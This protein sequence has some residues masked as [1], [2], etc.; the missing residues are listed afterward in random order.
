MVD[1]RDY[2]V[3]PD[4][5][6]FERIERRVRLRRQARMGAVAAVVVAA[7]VAV[8]L[9]LSRGNDDGYT[10]GEVESGKREVASSAVVEHPLVSVPDV[11]VES[12]RWKAENTEV[13]SGKRKMESPEVKSEKRNV[14]NN[15][16]HD[17]ESPLSTPVTLTPPVAQAPVSVR[18]PQATI[19]SST[20]QP[21]TTPLAELILED[22]VAG[23]VTSSASTAGS[24]ENAPSSSRY[25]D[26]LWA[27]NVVM[28]AAELD[29]NRL[30]RV[31]ASGEVH[32]FRLVVFNRGGRQVFSSSDI[33]TP[34]DATFD[35]SPVPQGAYVWVARFRDAEGVVR[36]E[37]GTV[38]VVR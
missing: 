35:G 11:E 25:N 34:W 8:P 20:V 1:L 32:D 23:N 2:K 12:G 21:V 7:M 29:Q 37:K 22:D 5:G 6:L 30:F 26:M 17:G 9:L 36:Q 4:A 14:K 3:Q 33:T 38:T 10:E 27:P 18:P 19:P 15:A 24:G 31:V 28:P 16:T 13:K